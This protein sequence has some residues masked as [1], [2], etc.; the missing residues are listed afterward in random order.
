MGRRCGRFVGVQRCR[1]STGVGVKAHGADQANKGLRGEEAPAHGRMCLPADSTAIDAAA[2][3]MTR[4]RVSTPPLIPLGTR[5]MTP[6]SANITPQQHDCLFRLHFPPLTD[7]VCT[8]V[9]SILRVG[10][11]RHV[12]SRYTI[13]GG[14][15]R[16]D[17][18]FWW[19]V[20]LFRVLFEVLYCI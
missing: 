14:V 15:N 9:A 20:E 2:A 1:G 11:C 4:V 13:A 16:G 6:C 10:M 17:C 19:C 3:A 5:A 12:P 8:T 7:V 18:V